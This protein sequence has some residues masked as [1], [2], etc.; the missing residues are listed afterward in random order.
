MPIWLNWFASDSQGSS[1]FCLPSVGIRGMCH[2]VSLFTW[3]LGFNSDP[4]AFEISILTTEPSP[5]LHYL[6]TSWGLVWGKFQ[7]LQREGSDPSSASCHLTVCVHWGPCHIP[8]RYLL[9]LEAAIQTTI[10]G[11]VSALLTTPHSICNLGSKNIPHLYLPSNA[12][13]GDRFPKC[14]VCWAYVYLYSELF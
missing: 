11:P 2:H 8:P 13:H 14:G 12:I 5:Q 3:V 6:K 4:H 10:F 9:T 7:R 1:C